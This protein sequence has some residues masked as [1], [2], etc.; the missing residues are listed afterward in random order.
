[1]NNYLDGIVWDPRTP[2]DY[3]EPQ[4]DERSARLRYIDLLE[5]V[6]ASIKDGLDGG[7]LQS[8]RIAF[9]SCALALGLG[10]C[11]GINVTQLSAEHGVQTET[12]LEAARTFAEANGLRPSSYLQSEL[13]NGNG[14]TEPI[15]ISRNGA[16]G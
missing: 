13:N 11:R 5:N 4:L 8:V 3:L 15:C 10:C 12:I 9:W 6:G 2:A 14:S 7:D 16:S 1:M